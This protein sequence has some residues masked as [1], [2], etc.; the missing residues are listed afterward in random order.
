MKALIIEDEDLAAKRLMQLLLEIEPGME[1]FGPIDSVEGA[2]KH[3][4]SVPSYELIFLDI[5]LADGKSFSIFDKVKINVPVIFTTAYDEYAIRAFELNSI[6]YLLKPINAEKLR[7]AIGK[8]KGIQEF[9][10]KEDVNRDLMEMIRS[11]QSK[12]LPVYKSRFLLNKGDML[13]PLSTREIAYFF[14]EDKV[15]FLTTLDHKKFLI[16]YTLEELELKL[17]PH[18]FFRVNRQFIASLDAI[19]KVH[20]YFN[21]KLKLDLCPDPEIEVIVSKART[22]DFKAWMNGE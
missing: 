11:L 22:S 7:N 14:A 8:F 21:Y 10:A 1:L 2:V 18:Q 3:L 20:N 9:Y 16:N 15:V 13:I 4:Q 5:Q 12:T 17:D 6:D 19:R